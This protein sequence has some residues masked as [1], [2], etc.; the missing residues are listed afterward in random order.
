MTEPKKTKAYKIGEFFGYS[1]VA[2]ILLA[3]VVGS[4]FVHLAFIRWGLRLWPL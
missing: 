4:F 2:I 3:M 1:V